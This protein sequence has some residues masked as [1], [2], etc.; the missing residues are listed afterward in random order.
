M[1]GDLLPYCMGIEGVRFSDPENVLSVSLIADQQNK[2]V[3]DELFCI[4]LVMY[5]A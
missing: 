3:Q 1:H 4:G 5:I 2:T